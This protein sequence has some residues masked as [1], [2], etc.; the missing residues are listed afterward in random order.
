MRLLKKGKQYGWSIQYFTY[1]GCD[2]YHWLRIYKRT[3]I[4]FFG[5]R[6]NYKEWRTI[7]Y[8]KGK[9]TITKD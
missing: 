8:N 6:V 7:L 5:N 3:F 9:I 4:G 1:W 2:D